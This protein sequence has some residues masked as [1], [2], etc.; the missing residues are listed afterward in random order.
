MT[1]RASQDNRLV[2]DP[3]PMVHDM[4]VGVVELLEYWSAVDEKVLPVPTSVR[5]PRAATL[6]G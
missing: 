1:H 2:S 6:N 4:T 3:P 5:P